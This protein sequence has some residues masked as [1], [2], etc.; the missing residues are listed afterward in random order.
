MERKQIQLTRQQAT[1]VRKEAA[2]R[3]TS[4]AAIVREAI[5]LWLQGRGHERSA[6]PIRRAMTVVGQFRSGRKN[7]SREHDREL[8]DVFRR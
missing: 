7:V 1:A 4:D 6:K 5:D 2:R 8:S 3:K